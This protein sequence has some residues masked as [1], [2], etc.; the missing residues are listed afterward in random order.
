M[1][2]AV[3]ACH[4]KREIAFQRCF[5]AFVEKGRIDTPGTFDRDVSVCP[6]G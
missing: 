1:Y 4:A 3:I 5:D 2:D 6:D